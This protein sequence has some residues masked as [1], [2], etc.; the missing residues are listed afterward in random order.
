MHSLCIDFVSLN[1]WLPKP[2]DAP[3]PEYLCWYTVI[4]HESKF[5][6]DEYPMTL[7]GARKLTTKVEKAKFKVE[8]HF[9]CQL[10]PLLTLYTI[11]HCYCSNEE[12]PEA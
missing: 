1:Q 9:F 6:P 4:S 5:T 10:A 12:S 8:F 3:R 7:Q 2:V 11:L